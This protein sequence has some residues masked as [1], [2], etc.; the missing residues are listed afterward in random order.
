MTRL[1]Q[2]TS[3]V[4]ASLALACGAPMRP[5]GHPEYQLR[6]LRARTPLPTTPP[7]QA[8]LLVVGA[9]DDLTVGPIGGAYD[10]EHYQ[11]APLQET[12]G[13]HALPAKLVDA[14]RTTLLSRGLRTRKDDLDLGHRLPYRA[15]APVVRVLR[16]TIHGFSFSRHAQGFDVLLGDV[17][18]RL[19]EGQTGNELWHGRQTLGFRLS[20]S[21]QD[22]FLAFA[23]ALTERL[24]SDPIFRS[25]LSG[26]AT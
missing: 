2:V 15:L 16:G 9:F 21:R 1:P 13:F 19:V 4:V 10:E 26:P 12:Y 7:Q 20:W 14:L 6:H 17:S 23:D 3:M 24:L 25:A 8:C 11:G 18:L 5:Y 22:P